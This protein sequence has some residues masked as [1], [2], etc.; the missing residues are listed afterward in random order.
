MLTRRQKGLVR[1]IAARHW[2][3][4]LRHV[5]YDSEPDQIAEAK[6][7]L[8]ARMDSQKETIFGS[9]IL[10]SILGPILMQLAIKLA[11]KLLE[12]WIEDRMFGGVVQG[13]EFRRGE[14]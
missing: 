13:T 11:I 12:K 8:T 7:L 5:V 9:S 3:D 6:R 2:N 4:S 10:V 14:L 1:K